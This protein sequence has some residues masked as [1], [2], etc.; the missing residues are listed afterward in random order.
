MFDNGILMKSGYKVVTHQK[1][2]KYKFLNRINHPFQNGGPK[3]K[4]YK[5]FY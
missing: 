2:M 3:I 4:W 1:P 5:E